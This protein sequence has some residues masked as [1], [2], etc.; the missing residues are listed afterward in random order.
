MHN[1]TSGVYDLNELGTSVNIKNNNFVIDVT[2]MTSEGSFNDALGA[3]IKDAIKQGS[4]E[5]WVSFSRDTSAKVFPLPI[6]ANGQIEVGPE[7]PIYQLFK[8]NNGKAVFNGGFIEVVAKGAGRAG[9]NAVLSTVEGSN[10]IDKLIINNNIKVPKILDQIKITRMPFDE[11][12]FDFPPFIPVIPGRPLEPTVEKEKSNQDNQQPS[13]PEQKIPTQPSISETKPE[14]PAVPEP[15]SSVLP[16]GDKIPHLAEVPKKED[17]K[18]V[19]EKKDDLDPIAVP[20]GRLDSS[21]D[22]PLATSAVVEPT[23]NPKVVVKP[24][25]QDNENKAAA[26]EKDDKGNKEPFK[27]SAEFLLDKKRKKVK[28]YHERI[29]NCLNGNP[30][31]G[32]KIEQLKKDFKQVSGIE[33]TEDFDPENYGKPTEENPVEKNAPAKEA[34]AARPATEET[35]ENKEFLERNKERI[36]SAEE[37]IAKIAIKEQ[38]SHRAKD[39]EKAIKTKNSKDV[40]LVML[41][42]NY[43]SLIFDDFRDSEYK[44]T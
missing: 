20:P 40:A 14:Q 2:R 3:D 41:K 27:G 33:W 37:A 31:E 42:A 4:A 32:D 44:N 11:M 16:K 22:V 1:K 12:P 13:T 25:G 26:K 6:G 7:S 43:D 24:E 19:V 29:L 10:I 36:K 34:K 23:I 39:L 17:G 8:N 30:K 21:A 18:G 35:E 38:R 28:S 5:V 9:R 15:E